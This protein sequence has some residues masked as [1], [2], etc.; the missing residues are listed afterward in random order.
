MLLSLH[1]QLSFNS[2][3][4]EPYGDPYRRPIWTPN[5]HSFLPPKIVDA[6]PQAEE[7]LTFV[8]ERLAIRSLRDSPLRSCTCRRTAEEAID[9]RG[10]TTKRNELDWIRTS[11]SPTHTGSLVTL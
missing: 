11:T 3:F 8:L 5:F 4:V 10:E 2:F 6:A 9:L 1:S 7:T